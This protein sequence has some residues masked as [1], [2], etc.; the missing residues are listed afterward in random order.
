M[1]LDKR[2]DTQPVASA[3][4]GRLLD[5]A[6]IVIR[7]KGYAATTIDDVCAEAGV[8]KGSFFH[9]FK[10]K[11]DLALAAAAYFGAMADGIFG[12]APYASLADPRDRLLG[13][14]RFRKAMLD[15]P[16]PEFTCLLG[17]MVQETYETHPAIRRAVDKYFGEHVTMLMKDIAAAKKHYAP[18]AKW[19]AE[20]LALFMQ[21]VIQGAFVL[22]KAKHSSNVAAE[23][24]DHLQRYIETQLP[25]P[26][27]P[28]GA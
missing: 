20:S 1:S 22:A 27:K 16:L 6:L 23:C 3:S 10:S 18:K 25:L 7:T 12:A 19:S 17:T 21:S 2:I 5:A 26:A 9:H 11:E 13:Y 4:K 8:T 28:K 15:R 24:L 14:V